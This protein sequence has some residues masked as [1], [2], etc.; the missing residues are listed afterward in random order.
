MYTILMSLSK[1][2]YRNNLPNFALMTSVLLSLIYFQL[3]LYCLLGIG[4]GNWP[5]KN[6]IQNPKK[7]SYGDLWGILPIPQLASLGDPA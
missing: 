1:I 2:I 7:F 6:Q 4:S 3:I 5:V